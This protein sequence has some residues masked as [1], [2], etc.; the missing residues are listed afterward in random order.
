MLD[1]FMLD[2]LLPNVLQLNNHRSMLPC[3]H[4]SLLDVSMLD[5]MMLDPSL[6]D[7]LPPGMLCAIDTTNGWMG[8][9]KTTSSYINGRL[10]PGPNSFK[11]I[12]TPNRKSPSAATLTLNLHPQPKPQWQLLFLRCFSARAK[13]LQSNR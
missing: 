4:A 3:F 12:G 10:S 8:S 1:A 13:L 2:N 11:L 5:A 6:L 7:N 9:E